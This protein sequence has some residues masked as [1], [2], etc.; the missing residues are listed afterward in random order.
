MQT[1]LIVS[2]IVI[3]IFAFLI[4]R[5]RAAMK[6]IPQVADHQ[7][8]LILTDKNI[9][10]QLKNKLVL[11]DFWASWCAPCRMMAPVLNEVAE[12]LSGNSNVAKVNIE[13]YQSL[14]QKYSVRSI[15]TLILFKNG[16]E[17]DRFA[18]VKTKDYLLK[19]IQ[20]H[21]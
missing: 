15:P 17:V 12:E 6:N 3:S 8:I 10:Q 21:S 20:K 11:A 7:K 1:T 9:Q 4:L 5:A 18:G 2:I 19:Q 14:A 16:I 13:Q